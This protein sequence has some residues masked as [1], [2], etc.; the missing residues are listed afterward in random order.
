[1]TI[2]KKELFFIFACFIWI[3]PFFL[4]KRY[5]VL[6]KC[7]LVLLVVLT[8]KIQKNTLLSLS[9]IYTGVIILSTTLFDWGAWNLINTLSILSALLGCVVCASNPTGV[10]AM[11]EG[12]LKGFLIY[13]LIDSFFIFVTNGVGTNAVGQP[14]YFSGGKFNVCYMYLLLTVLIFLKYKKI[15]LS[16][17]LCLILFGMILALRVD[18]STGLL[19][20]IAFGGISLLPNWL[21]SGKK[22]YLWLLGTLWIH[23]LIVF[24][25]IQS[26]NPLL[27]YIITEVLHR[28]V[29][30]T[31][32]VDIYNN[33][34]KIM[35]GHW[36][37]GYGYTSDRIVEITGLANTQNG[38]LQAIYIGGI[39]LFLI[40]MILL[41]YM[42]HRIS[43]IEKVR[44]QNILFSALMAFLI[45]AIVEIP[46][47]S[48]VFYLLLSIIYVYSCRGKGDANVERFT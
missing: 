41:I 44:E 18:C 21:K 27:R 46:F 6:L 45:I 29:H 13:F 25:Q 34:D 23:Y 12:I 22:K 36:L 47:T 35:E 2:N 11:P 19:A 32:R 14:V 20:M 26:T 10:K 16:H 5:A 15:K 48:V 38:F 4:P 28:Q 8:Q 9:I 39:V 30:L 43:K 37:L 17:Q 7:A 1:M 33:F 31:G 3:T 24:V 40:F 42:L